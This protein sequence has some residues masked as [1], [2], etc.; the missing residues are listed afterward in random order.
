MSKG[1]SQCWIPG[2][3]AA[4]GGTTASDRAVAEQRADRETGPSVPLAGDLAAL[5]EPDLI[6]ACL[7]GHREAF[8]LIVER[9]RRPVYQVCYRFVG[10]HADASDLA[11]DVFLRAYRALCQFRGQSTLSTWLHRI[12]VN[13]SLNHVSSRKPP[14]EAIDPERHVDKRSLDPASAVLRGEQA[15]HVRAAIAKL[16]PKQRSTLV[17]RVYQELSHEEIAK[18]LG[19]SVGAVKANFFHALGNLRKLLA[20]QG[21][22]GGREE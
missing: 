4:W 14:T 7:D 3:V 15:R 1:E 8:D 17:L 21:T 12:A 2:V 6:R 13:V 9:H 19:S 18:I 10:N 16:P 20:G 11:Q 22:P 5:A